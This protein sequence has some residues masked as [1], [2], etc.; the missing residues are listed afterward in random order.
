MSLLIVYPSSMCILTVNK[1][2]R[3]IK[4][5]VLLLSEIHFSAIHLRLSEYQIISRSVYH[6]IELWLN[7]FVHNSV[8]IL[9]QLYKFEM[10]GL[11][12]VYD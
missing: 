5:N 9:F 7:V 6:F 10:Y 2:Y 4:I 11:E 8:Y 12:C 3:E 1:K